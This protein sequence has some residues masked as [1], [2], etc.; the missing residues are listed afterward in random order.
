[1]TEGGGGEGDGDGLNS[2]PLSPHRLHSCRHD[3][4]NG[5]RCSCSCFYRHRRHRRTS[6][7]WREDEGTVCA[8]LP[9]SRRPVP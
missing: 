4:G 6:L 2:Q 5:C 9:L 7:S 3:C 1:M 8:Y